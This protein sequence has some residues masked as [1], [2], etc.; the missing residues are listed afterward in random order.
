VKEEGRGV[1]R[2]GQKGA[3]TKRRREKTTKKEETQSKRKT[4]AKKKTHQ[5]T[6]KR[7]YVEREY[8]FGSTILGK[9]GMPLLIRFGASGMNVPGR[10]R[11]N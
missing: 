5:H 1:G 3:K 11:V 9:S 8:R 7:L 10:R 4:Q 6:K 2:A